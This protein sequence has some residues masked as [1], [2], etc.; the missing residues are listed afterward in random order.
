MRSSWPCCCRCANR[1][2]EGVLLKQDRGLGIKVT[3]AYLLS[4]YR[5]FAPF[6]LGFAAASVTAYGGGA[7]T[8]AMLMR[9][10]AMTPGQIGASFGLAAMVA[11]VIG[12]LAAGALVDALAKRQIRTAKLAMLAILPIAALP[13]A[14]AAF[15]P[16]PLTAVL[17]AAELIMIFPMIGTTMITA[18]QEMVPNDMRGVSVSLFGVTNTLIGAIGGPLLIATLT[19]HVFGDPKSVGLSI[20]WV[21]APALIASSLIFF[22]GWRALKTSLATDTSLSRIM[23]AEAA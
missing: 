23:S 7:W 2:A 21:C 19:D 9:D 4:N 13:S 18:V 1:S 14:F 17:L 12:T 20:A 22:V 3:A 15:A 6:Y 8:A 16:T 10:F 11:G 5:V